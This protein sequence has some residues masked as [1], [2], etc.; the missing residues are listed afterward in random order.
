MATR[1]QIRRELE[2]A[3]SRVVS[4]MSVQMLQDLRD[5][6]RKDTQYHSSRWVGRA[7]GSPPSVTTPNSR[8]GRA[9][10]LSFGQ[11]NASIASL[12]AY[13]VQQGNVTIANDGSYIAQLDA[14]DGFVSRAV[15][16]AIRVSLAGTGLR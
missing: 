6:T 5:D 13:R 3:I 7:G 16:R 1:A 11:H 4:R 2:G 8:T 10:A 14:Q 9:A 15:S 12:S